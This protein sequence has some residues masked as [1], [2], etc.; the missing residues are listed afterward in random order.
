M[1]SGNSSSNI[2]E[3]MSWSFRSRSRGS[4]L[5]LFHTLATSSRILAIVSRRLGIGLDSKVSTGSSRTRRTA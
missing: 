3:P 2:L 1:S 5:V 4:A